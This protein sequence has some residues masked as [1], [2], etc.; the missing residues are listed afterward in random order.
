MRQNRGFT[1]IELLVVIAI[2]GILLA[3]LI[4]AL[5]AAKKQVTGIICSSNNRALAQSWHLYTEENNA[6]LPGG[7][8]YDDKQW[9]GPPRTF[10]GTI[11][12]SNTPTSLDDE[13]RKSDRSHVVL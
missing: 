13:F 9:I 3:I 12:T 4:P 8:T 11:I 2:I 1:L 7:N 6:S 5:R 10:N